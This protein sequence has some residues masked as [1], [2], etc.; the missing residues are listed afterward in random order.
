MDGGSVAEWLERFEGPPPGFSQYLFSVTPSS[1]PWLHFVYSQ[2]LCLLPVGV[3][4]KLC[5]VLRRD[6]LISQC[7]S[8]PRCTNGTS[9]YAGDNPTMDQHPIQ[10]G[11]TILLAASC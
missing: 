5:C 7:F 1:T 8:A 3:F 4:L 11:V 2:L 9:K 10:G 6:T